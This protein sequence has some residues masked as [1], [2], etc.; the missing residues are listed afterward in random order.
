[1]ISTYLEINSWLN[2]QFSNRKNGVFFDSDDLK[3]FQLIQDFIETKEHPTKT[4]AIYYQAFADEN[5]DEFLNTLEEELRSKLGYLRSQSCSNM[6]EVIA[7]SE[8]R[9]IFIDRS[10]LW[11]REMIDGLSMWLAEHQVGLILIIS[12]AKIQ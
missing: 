9:T 11:A 10:Y 3:S 4:P 8:L 2:T 12:Q 7:A 1:M 6:A 5:L